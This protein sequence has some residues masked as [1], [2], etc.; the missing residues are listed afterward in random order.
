MSQFGNSDMILE[1]GYIF[2]RLPYPLLTVHRA[3][4]TY[5]YQ[6][7][8]YNLMNFLE[9]VSDRYV[10]INIDH[11]FN[12]FIFNRLPLIRHLDLREVVTAKVLY[13]GIR[14]ENDPAKNTDLYRYPAVNGIPTTFS[15]ND[16]PY[17][18]GSVGI[19]NIFKLLRVDVVKRFTYRDHPDIA[20]WGIRGRVRFE[21]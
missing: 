17:I 4:Q 12:G 1:G 2:G 15:L 8:S 20:K 3:N 19:S 14:S 21:F 5:A 16:G 7:A 6:L 11:H 13:G 18:E 9:F 10:S